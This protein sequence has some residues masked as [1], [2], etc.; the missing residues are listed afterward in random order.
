[1]TR[2]ITDS[3][4]EPNIIIIMDGHTSKQTDNDILIPVD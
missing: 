3:R 4:R 2:Q 1:M